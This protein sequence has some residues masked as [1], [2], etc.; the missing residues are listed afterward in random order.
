MKIKRIITRGFKTYRDATTIGEFDDKLNCIVGL[1]GSGK[2]SIFQ[3]IIFALCGATSSGGKVLHEGSTGKAM[4]GFV[5]IEF[6]GDDS[7]GIKSIRRT[8]ISGGG[9]EYL[10]NEKS[11]PKSDYISSLQSAGLLG[12]STSK[13]LPY[14]I[15]EQ[16]RVTSVAT[17]SESARFELLKEA[18]GIDVFGEK[19]KESIRI[20]KETNGKRVKISDLMT[21]IESRCSTLARESDEMAEYSQLKKEKEFFEY[22]IGLVEIASLENQKLNFNRSLNEARERIDQLKNDILDVERERDAVVV[23][24]GTDDTASHIEEMTEKIRLL[25]LSL[26]RAQSQLTIE[27]SN[28]EKTN[29]ALAE[30]QDQL[31]SVQARRATV[32]TEVGNDRE[33]FLKLQSQ[34]GDLTARRLDIETEI[35]SIKSAGWTLEELQSHEAQLRLMLAGFEIRLKQFRSQLADAESEV[36][37]LQK[38]EILEAQSAIDSLTCSVSEYDK[39][40][41]TEILESNKLEFEKKK[42]LSE[43]F[44]RKNQELFSHQ[45]AIEGWKKELSVLS[46][47]LFRGGVSRFTFSDGFEDQEKIEGVYGLFGDFIKIPT[48]YRRAVEIAAKNILFNVIIE[49]DDVADRLVGKTG[50]GRITLVPLNRIP[51]T[52]EGVKKLVE[53]IQSDTEFKDRVQVLSS[54]ITPVIAENPTPWVEELIL[55][56][57]GKIA[58]VESIDVGFALSKKYGIDS[59]TADGDLINKHLIL[60]SAP[61]VFGSTGSASSTSAGGTSYANSSNSMQVVL[62]W[63]KIIELRRKIKLEKISMKSVIE[64]IDLLE[65]KLHAIEEQLSIMANSADSVPSVLMAEKRAELVSA[66]R[67]FSDLSEKRAELVNFIIPNIRDIDIKGIENEIRRVH[68]DLVSVSEKISSGGEESGMSAVDR[69]NRLHVLTQESEKIRESIEIFEKEISLSSKRISVNM[70]ELKYFIGSKISSIE[71]VIRE[72]TMDGEILKNSVIPK[73]LT[74]INFIRDVEL[75]SNQGILD[76]LLA[77]KKLADDALMVAKSETESFDSKIAEMHACIADLEM[78]ILDNQSK[79]EKISQNIIAIRDTTDRRLTSLPADHAASESVASD[80]SYLRSE[81]IRLSKI[82]SSDKFEYMNRNAVEQHERISHEKLQL[83]NRRDEIDASHNALTQLLGQ[84]YDREKILILS[85]FEKAKLYFESLFRR[86]TNGLGDASMEMHV[87]DSSAAEMTGQEVSGTIRIRIAFP[88]EETTDWKNMSELSGGQR[89]VV[90][91]CY[92]LSLHKAAAGNGEFFILDEVDAA[93][94]SSYR[95]ALADAVRDDSRKTGTQFIYTSFRPEFAAVADKHFLVTMARGTS[96][97]DSVDIPTA[98]SLIHLQEKGDETGFA[99]EMAAL[100]E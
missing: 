83:I 81:I 97:V 22:K 65:S 100:H 76:S 69:E 59:V 92:L 41:E 8:T 34:L 5:E 38:V 99:P 1:N 13:K 35:E 62:N 14:Y 93:L 90:A 56:N 27:E 86:I 79:L 4:S 80:L 51:P 68:A 33:N 66:Q 71:E 63:Q 96:R 88:S 87:E 26:S 64:N 53:K 82:L 72:R 37:R 20:L 43:I 57:F 73:L 17:L 25:S 61:P 23:V 85:S 70:S 98:L 12:A 46:N 49:S 44:T 47:G 24:A 78:E 31:E 77:S 28:L 10:V 84:L 19:Q 42:I 58:I 29:S 55:K 94:D 45:K 36:N 7:D 50:N 52:Q 16:G 40:R 2:S 6:A 75:V 15:V 39:K 74:E 3:A 54:V 60:R 21:D 9:D 89:T 30:L 91:L 18:C 95:S 11:V 48:H 67:R 32:E